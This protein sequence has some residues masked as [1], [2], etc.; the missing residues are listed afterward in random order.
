[1]N[2]K[3]VTRKIAM[4]LQCHQCLGEYADSRQDCEC[5]R[6][7]L[8]PWMP[9]RKMEPDLEIFDYNPRR[10]GKVTW[11]ESKREMTEEQ[12]AELSE[13]MK[14]MHESNETESK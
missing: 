12:H 1:M 8:Y 10:V 6:C 11:E 13:R 4:E 14:K 7:S 3:K 2:H 5:V 9:Y